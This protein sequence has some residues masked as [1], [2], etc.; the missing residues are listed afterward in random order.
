MS[1]RSERIKI[2]TGGIFSL[3][4]AMGVARFS[5]TPLL[6]LMQKQAGLGVTEAGLLAAINYAGYLSGAIAASLISSQKLKVRLYVLGL[7]AAVLTTAMMGVSENV[8][9]WGLSRYLAGL[10]TAAAMLMGSGLILNWLIRHKH[11]SE[12]GIHFSGVGIGIAVCSA[13]VA[14]MNPELN[15]RE[16]WYA[17]T[18]LGA[19]L[20]IPALLWLPDTGQTST[21]PVGQ[22]PPDNPPTPLFL[23]VFM[24]SYFCAGIGYVV[25]A[26]FIVSIIDG[27]PDMH[28][29]GTLVFLL[30][31]VAGAPSCVLWDL[32]ARRIGDLNAVTVASGLQILGIILPVWPGGL[33]AALIGSL[34]FGATVMGLVSLVLTMAGRYYPAHPAKMLGKMS[35][36]YGSA[37]IVGPAVTGWLARGSG[38][39]SSGLYMAAGVMAIGFVLLLWLRTMQAPT[40]TPVVPQA[41]L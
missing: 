35:I 22:V 33:A 27:L 9:I 14:V 28:G 12:L 41:D 19:L 26:T 29:R 24:A 4:L 3:I 20:A 40:S 21:T 30:I 39:Y 11:R 13:A 6:P 34:L 18:G 15:W 8:W 5:Y 38:G 32:V 17:F 10:S 16:Q 31:G 37:Q 1:A 36:A 25:S 7:A 2:L 23:R